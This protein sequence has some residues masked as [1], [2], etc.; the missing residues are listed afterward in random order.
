MAD[1]VLD[2]RIEH[3]VEHDELVEGINTQLPADNSVP[4]NGEIVFN[5]TRTNFKVGDG[6]KTYSQLSNFVK[7]IAAASGEHINETNIPTVT[8]STA[9]DTTTFTF[10]YLKGETGAQGT[11]ISSIVC[12]SSSGLVDTYTI[13]YTNSSTS[14]FTV[15][16]GADGTGVAIKAS[17][18]ECTQIGD[19]YIDSNGC[20]QV[21]TSLNPRIFTN[22]GEIKGPQGDSLSFNWDGT[23][24]GVRVGDSGAYSYV[25]LKG[26]DGTTPTV[27]TSSI[28]G[29]HNVAFSYGQGDSRNTNFDV[30]DGISPAVSV[31]SITGGHQISITDATHTTIPLTFNVLDGN[32]GSKWHSGTAVTTTTSA[33]PTGVVVG[34]YYLNTSTSDVWKCISTTNNTKWGFVCNIKGYSPTASVTKLNGIATITITDSNGTTTE[35]V[36]D[37]TDGVDGATWFS[38]TTN[39]SNVTNA[40][41]GDFYLNTNTYHIYEC[42]AIINNV[43]TWNDKGSIKGVDGWGTFN[44]RGGAFGND[45]SYNTAYSD[46]TKNTASLYAYNLSTVNLFAGNNITFK[47]VKAYGDTSNTLIGYEISAT[48]G[49]GSYTLPI[50]SANTLGGIMVG[51]NL[52]ISS[53]GTLSATDT[54]YSVASEQATEGLLITGSDFEEPPL[55]TENNSAISSVPIHYSETYKTIQGEEEVEE[56]KPIHS[57]NIYDIILAIQNDENLRAAFKSALEGE[58]TPTPKE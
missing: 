50:A 6:S 51:S 25:D 45:Y 42:T 43:Q 39:P 12:T 56:D 37:G 17:E 40:K 34:D 8:A 16:N 47:P 7:T 15:T 1:N 55:I 53:N 48:G 32:D 44:F 38:G 28:Q 22:A 19:A 18:V 2:V 35:T 49:G 11:G 14:T 27:T 26:D 30:M 5:R 13:T 23:Q 9:G 36:S 41:V 24:L 58:Y 33:I 10:D 20:L 29:G 3:A 57:V 54:T 46:L 52:S 21:L 31:S 4:K